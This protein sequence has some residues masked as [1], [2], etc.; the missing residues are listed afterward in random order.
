M[1][2]I[3]MTQPNYHAGGEEIAGNWP[4]NSQKYPGK[5]P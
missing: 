4:M 3:M 5:L 1:M 2:K